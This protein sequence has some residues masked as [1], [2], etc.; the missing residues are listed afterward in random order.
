[1]KTENEVQVQV[2]KE[3]EKG[4]KL[5]KFASRSKAFLKTLWKEEGSTIIGIA[6]GGAIVGVTS[7]LINS[8]KDDESEESEDCD[9]IDA[10]YEV[11]EEEEEEA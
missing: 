8:I 11:V 7:L 5:H 10:D 1:M 6:I 9:Y 2:I 4:G 3:E